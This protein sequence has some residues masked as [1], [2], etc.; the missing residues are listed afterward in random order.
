M[1]I[2]MFWISVQKKYSV[3]FSYKNFL[4]SVFH[5]FKI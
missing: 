2:I 1:M 3:I 5:Y 4:N